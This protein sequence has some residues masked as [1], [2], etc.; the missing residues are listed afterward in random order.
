MRRLFLAAAFSLGLF[1]AGTA[2]AAPA[3]PPRPVAEM[4][5]DATPV[6]YRDRRHDDRRSHRPAPRYVAPRYVTPL[7]YRGHAYAAPQRRNW[8]A[9][10][11][12]HRYGWR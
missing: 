9:P 4:A 5:L 1:A 3:T 12:G 11:R 8:H 7:R 10:P 6:Q 2:N